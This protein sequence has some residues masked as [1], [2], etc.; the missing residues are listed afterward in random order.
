MKGSLLSVR[1]IHYTTNARKKSSLS[2]TDSTGSQ[3]SAMFRFCDGG[4]WISLSATPVYPHIQSMITR[5]QPPYRFRFHPFIGHKGPYG[6]Q[7]YSS[8]LFLTSTLEGVRDQR[9]A[10]AAPHPRERPGIHFTGGWVGLRAGAENLAPTGIRSP[11]RPAR[12]QS[13][14]RLRYPAHSEY[15]GLRKSYLTTPFEKWMAESVQW[16]GFGMDD[17]GFEFQQGQEI[18]RFSSTPRFA[19]GATQSPIHFFTWG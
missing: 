19:V 14:Y 16:L 7:R 2:V 12:R 17:S 1:L 5:S 9:H 4:I 10:P 3:L 15:I 18:F 6:E 8:T 13:L 11:N